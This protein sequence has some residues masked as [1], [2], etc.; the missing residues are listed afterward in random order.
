MVHVRGTV[1]NC[2]SSWSEQ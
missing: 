2:H 1:I